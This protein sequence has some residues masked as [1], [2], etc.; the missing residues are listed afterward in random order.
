MT[1]SYSKTKVMQL[2]RQ[3]KISL[4]EDN[5]ASSLITI[6][7]G[8]FNVMT[9]LGDKVSCN[10]MQ[11]EKLFLEKIICPTWGSLTKRA[12]NTLPLRIMKELGIPM[13]EFTISRL[14]IQEFNQGGQRAL[15]IIRMNL[16]MEDIFSTALFHV[17]D[18]KTSY[19]MLPGQPWKPQPLKGFVQLTQGP[20][21]E[22]EEPSKLQIAKGFDPKTYKFLVKTGYNSQE[23]DVLGKLSPKT[24]G[25]QTY[26]LNAT[27][28]MLREKGHSVQ[29]SRSEINLGDVEN[30]RPIYIS[31]L[32]TDNEEVAYVELL[33]EFKDVFAWSYKEMPGLDSKVAVHQLSI[34]KGARP[35]KQAQCRFRPELVPLIEVEVNKLIEVGF[36]IE[37]KYLTWI[38]S[39]V[40][41]RKKNG[42]IRPHY[43]KG[44]SFE[45]NEACHNAF[46]SIKSYLMKP[47]VLVA[48]VPGRP[49]ILYIAAQ[50]CSVGALLAQENNEGKE[51]TL[52]YLSRMMTPNELKYSPIEKICLALSDPEIETLLPSTYCTTCLQSKS[53]Q[54]L[55]LYEV[56]KPELFLYFDYAQK[57]IR[58][59]GDVEIEHVPRKD[60][61]QADA[62]AKLASTLT[63]LEDDARVP[64]SIQERLIEEENARL[65]F[66]ELEALDEKRL[67][68]Q[69]RLKC[70][71]AHLSRAFNK[72][73]R[74][75]SFQVGDLVLA[76]KRPIITTHCTGNKFTSK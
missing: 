75:H 14:M 70:Y 34:R 13:N 17:I 21:K 2:A 23:R 36:I 52:Y 48:P 47:P 35:I 54:L 26:G 1:A 15:G 43:E 16:L 40:P 19:N 71:Q 25:G 55:G 69:Q 57:L 5:A 53:T 29:N 56:K 51:S 39:I 41:V 3:G 49:L 61:K 63:T 27:Q 59:L 4:E 37:V 6:T 38:S 32:L 46:R 28:K 60:N 12:F 8:S 11:E 31:A 68:A 22:H 73:V 42:Q 20:E 7:F 44:V 24:E 62:L 18:A 9:K 45:S 64:I 50:E 76:V 74:S 65:R 58:W 67:E 10:M 72:K 66:E 33:H 30:P